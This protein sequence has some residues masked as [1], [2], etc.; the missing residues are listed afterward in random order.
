MGK[1]KVKKVTEIRD[2]IFFRKLLDAS[3]NAVFIGWSNMQRREYQEFLRDYLPHLR[4]LSTIE[5]AGFTST[6]I[7]VGLF[8]F[9]EE[10]SD[11]YVS[12]LYDGNQIVAEKTFDKTDD[13]IEVARRELAPE[14]LRPKMSDFF[15]TVCEYKE[16][17]A[18]QRLSV[19]LQAIKD[20]EDGKAEKP[21]DEVADERIGWE[22]GGNA[23]LSDLSFRNYLKSVNHDLELFGMTGDM[24]IL[25]ALSANLSALAELGQKVTI[26][27]EVLRAF[28]QASKQGG[29]EELSLGRGLPDSQG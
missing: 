18:K 24:S 3:K 13:V 7:S 29:R 15:Q 1:K 12:R 20:W 21:W 2:I 22:Q 4:E 25:Y 27:L 17:E 11:S 19:K 26:Q 5:N 23:M 6:N 8:V 10:T 28:E 9:S 16:F 14:D